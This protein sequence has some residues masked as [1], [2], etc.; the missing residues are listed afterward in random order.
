MKATRPVRHDV[1]IYAGGT[2]ICA[3]P[4]RPTIATAQERGEAP[5]LTP[6][7]ADMVMIE[8]I[9]GDPSSTWT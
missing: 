2:T 4:S 3:C 9:A 6:A 1:P 8:E 5:K 7:Q